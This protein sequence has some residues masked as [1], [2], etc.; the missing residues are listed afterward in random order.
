VGVLPSRV[1]TAVGVAARDFG[2]FANGTL[3]ARGLAYRRHDVPVF[4]ERTQLAMLAVLAEAEELARVT[5]RV[6]G[7]LE[8]LRAVQL[9]VAKRVS[10]GPGAY[11]VDTA[12]A[13][14]LRQIGEV[15]SRLHP[16][17]RVRSLNRH[18]H[19][20]N[21]E[22]RVRAFPHLGA[23]DGFDVAQYQTMMLDTALEL[24]VPFGYDAARL[25]QALR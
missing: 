5:A 7:A 18:A 21:H 12:A 2:V 4:L 11:Q 22:E 3:K 6:P 20:P 10:R 1:R 17:E 19:A 8:I 16:G 14:A 23:D 25:R 24:L 15:G 13:L 9:L